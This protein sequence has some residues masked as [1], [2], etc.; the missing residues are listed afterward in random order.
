MYISDDLTNHPKYKRL[1]RLIGSG[2]VLEYLIRLWGHCVK[3]KRGEYWKE[4]DE[5]YIA[6]VAGWEKDPKDLVRILLDTKWLVKE[7]QVRFER[8]DFVRIDVERSD[9]EAAKRRSSSA[10]H[11][12]VRLAA[13]VQYVLVRSQCV[14]FTNLASWTDPTSKFTEGAKYRS[15]ST[16]QRVSQAPEWQKGGRSYLTR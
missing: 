13:S 15:E 1:R 12:F 9:V 7:E 11:A 5:D 3:D 6:D 2:D 16:R 8:L 10:Q 14:P 4:A